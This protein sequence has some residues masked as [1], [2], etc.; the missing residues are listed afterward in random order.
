MLKMNNTPIPDYVLRSKIFRTI[1][2]EIGYRLTGRERGSN[3]RSI[4]W[5][6]EH[7]LVSENPFGK[8]ILYMNWS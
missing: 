6:K 7:K 5:L 4:N 3:L 2:P 8:P 1:K